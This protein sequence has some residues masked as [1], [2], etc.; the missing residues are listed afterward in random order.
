M[1]GD[2]FFDSN[3]D[4]KLTG[5][6][7]LMRDTFW[8]DQQRRWNNQSNDYSDDFDYSPSYSS[9]SYDYDD[10]DDYDW[11]DEVTD[12]SEY[13]IDPYDFE[14]PEEYQEALEEAAEKYGELARILETPIPINISV[15]VADSPSVKPE[16]YPNKRRFEAADAI[17]SDCFVFESFRKAA[18]FV[19]EKADEILAAN[20]LSYSYGFLYAQA[21]KDNFDL[22]CS[23]PNEDEKQ[24]MEF[25]EILVKL[26]K[27][28]VPL[29]LKV[30][31][32]CVEQFGP[33]IEYD[34]Y[35]ANNLSK[36]IFDRL[37]SFSNRDEFV[38]AVIHYF[39]D[40]PDFGKSVMSL[41]SE[42][43]YNIGEFI[44]EAIIEKRFGVAEMMFK[45]ELY[46]V[47]ED[48]R[49]IL[50]LT[51]DIITFCSS[52][53]E[54][55][56]LEYFR[57]NFF[58]IIK[59]IPDGM[60]Q[61]EIP[62]FEKTIAENISSIEDRS[63][64][65][66]YSGKNAWRTRVPD[67]REYGLD[68]LCYDS[69]RE[70]LDDLQE[71]KYGW[72]DYYPASGDDYG[73]DVN[74]YET[75]DDFLNALNAKRKEIYE[76]QR[77]EAIQKQIELQKE[78]AKDTTIYTYCGVLLPNSPRPLSYRTDDDTIKIGDS[79]IVPYGSNNE[80]KEGTVVSVG[81]YARLGVPYPVERTKS[82]IRKK[83]D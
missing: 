77:A 20:Y 59:A 62:E 82:I 58:P 55:E 51:D 23:L 68:P 73:L 7:T 69:E 24:E 16:D 74:D 25:Y 10:E 48:W 72:R 57:D 52:G 27:R 13:G 17:A 1:L 50:S 37:Y 14:T 66:A 12:C 46:K 21:I 41:S 43:Y 44:A 9:P 3:N 71:A 64:R 54:I 56:S 32:W 40:N 6:E 76:A 36:D 75:L 53:E 8:L 2:G 18:H 33:Y 15:S 47:K 38:S 29:T 22:P 70:Y 78:A 31:K 80:E 26:A 30:W 79:V 65:Y 81:Q 61:D 39:E 19:V 11:R 34:E 28:D 67:G 45:S 35:A 83:D 42:C 60:V 4:G 49:S 5:F 63:E